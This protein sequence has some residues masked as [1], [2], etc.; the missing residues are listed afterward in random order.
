M[1]TLHHRWRKIKSSLISGLCLLCAVVVIAPLAFVLFYLLKAGASSLDAAFFTQ[2]PKPAGEVG[3][4]MANAIAGSFILLGLAALVGV[5]IG[6]LGGIYLSEFGKPRLNGAVRF[7]A[8]ILNGVP[9][10]VWGIVVWSLVVGPMQGF[11]AYAG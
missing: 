8:D 4:G 5:P 1:N 2:L 9:S 10:I 7:A 11:S 6:V 3:G